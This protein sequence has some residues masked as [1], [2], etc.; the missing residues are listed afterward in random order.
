[1]KRSFLRQWSRHALRAF[2]ALLLLLAC[3]DCLRAAPI[4]RIT[5][6]A[7]GKLSLVHIEGQTW[8]KCFQIVQRESGFQIQVPRMPSGAVT[9]RLERLD[10][11]ERLLDVIAE[12]K[13]LT[14]T[15]NRRKSFTLNP[16]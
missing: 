10:S 12:A 3:A 14:V 1:M 13:N 7:A 15:R 11:W 8:S 4:E 9:M 6:D 2:V 5:Y 16:K